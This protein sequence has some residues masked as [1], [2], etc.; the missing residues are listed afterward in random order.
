MKRVKMQI[1]YFSLTVT[2]PLVKPVRWNE[3]ASFVYGLPE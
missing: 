3:A 2:T 1:W